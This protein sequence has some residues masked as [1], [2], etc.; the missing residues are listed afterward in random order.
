[1]RE[2]KGAKK[3]ESSTVVWHSHVTAVSANQRAETPALRFMKIEEY[4]RTVYCSVPIT[5]LPRGKRIS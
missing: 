2:K 4:V 5:L 1:M 3:K